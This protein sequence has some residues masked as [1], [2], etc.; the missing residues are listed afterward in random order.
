MNFLLTEEQ[1]MTR[2]MVRDF[3]EK[4]IKPGA[5]ERDEKEEF[6]R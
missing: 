1:E 5:E 2:K 6:S 4:E 3:A